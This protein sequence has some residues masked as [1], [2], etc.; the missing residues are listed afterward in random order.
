MSSHSVPPVSL[1]SLSL[2][3]VTILV[4][5]LQPFESFSLSSVSILW[6]E[7]LTCISL[8]VLV[9]GVVFFLLLFLTFFPL[10]ILLVSLLSLVRFTINLT[11]YSVFLDVLGS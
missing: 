7:S 4:R 11:V 10:R 1:E 8:I 3:I 5:L 6:S 9:L 2:D